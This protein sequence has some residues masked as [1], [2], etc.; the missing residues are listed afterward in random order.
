MSSYISLKE[1]NYCLELDMYNND[2]K[3]AIEYNDHKKKIR[4]QSE[5]QFQ[6]QLKNDK[7][8]KEICKINKVK[9]IYV[10][11]MKIEEMDQQIM[12]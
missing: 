1:N 2:L 4:L 9:L 8:K 10:P 3:V 6:S 11:L 7:L 5:K 12:E